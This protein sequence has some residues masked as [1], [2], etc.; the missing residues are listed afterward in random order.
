MLM[1]LLPW[2]FLFFGLFKCWSA[3][4]RDRGKLRVQ[5]TINMVI[6][7]ILFTDADSLNLP[8]ALVI[9]PEY[10]S[11]DWFKSVGILPSWFVGLSGILIALQGMAGL[12]IGWKLL[13]RSAR[14]D[15]WLRCYLPFSSL[16][17]L[18]TL[19]IMM[20]RG[21]YL[22]SAMGLQDLAV[23][24]FACLFL[25]IIY[26]IVYLIYRSAKMNILFAHETARQPPVPTRTE[27]L[28]ELDEHDIVT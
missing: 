16:G 21:D 27:V 2:I 23:P 9:R 12:Y 7:L 1:K 26:F 4:A 22:H 10:I 18:L 24:I 28:P 25:G 17:D 20:A 3:C 11:T 19:V 8:I 5:K 15:R 13:G 6:A 14:A